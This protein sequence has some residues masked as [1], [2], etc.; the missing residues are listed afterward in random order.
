MIKTL[1]IDGFR[2]IR[3]AKIEDLAPLTVFVG[4]N[5]A[6]KTT[7]LEAMLIAASC[8]PRTTLQHQFKEHRSLSSWRWLFFRE[9][10]ECT[11]SI[12]TEKEKLATVVLQTKGHDLRTVVKT[13]GHSGQ[14]IAPDQKV[15]TVSLIDADVA[16]PQTPLTDVYTRAVERGRRNVAQEIV[17]E[18][19]AGAS[20]IEILT[21]HGKA[22]MHVVFDTFSVPIHLVGD[23]IQRVMRLALEFASRN[24]GTVLL[25]EP[26][27]FQHPAAIRQTA[28]AIRSSV[29]RGLQI[30]LSTHSL[31]LIDALLNDAPPGHLQQ[32]AFYRVQLNNGELSSSRLSG[33]E[34]KL[35]RQ[36]IEDDLR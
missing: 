8:D 12:R 21:E 31:E 28:L 15:A 27:V 14:T 30:I 2:G 11:I 23:G 19:L 36:Q 10:A 13:G 4:P 26:E 34:A 9:Q 20:G 6:G 33:E 1:E 17:K 32:M 22:V 3:S 18:V 29:A 16:D 5:G 25:E 7:L 24:E 35:A